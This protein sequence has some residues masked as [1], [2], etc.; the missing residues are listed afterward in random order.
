[1]SASFDK[2]SFDKNAKKAIPSLFFTLCSSVGG[3]QSEESYNVHKCFKFPKKV[4]GESG[5][6][7][8]SAFLQQQYAKQD[9]REEDLSVATL[10][11]IRK[12]LRD[13]RFQQTPV[14]SCS[15]PIRSSTKLNISL[16]ANRG[17]TRRA[18]LI[19]INYSGQHGHEL[20]SSHYDACRLANMLVDC[21]GYS[22]ENIVVLLDDGKHDAPTKRRIEDA[23]LHLANTCESGDFN[24]ISFSGHG[25]Q[26]VDRSGDEESGFDS[27]IIPVDAKTNG[28][29]IDDDSKQ[30]G[31]ISS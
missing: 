12:S 8:V 15:R 30:K 4:A 22:R 28:Q 25:G 17:G 21:H 18:I 19:G 13:N 26:I 10:L 9:K 5:S 11:E 1:M 7:C 20:K 27:S 2:D 23:F 3:E 6:V 24:F 14:M 31:F 16:G 29:V